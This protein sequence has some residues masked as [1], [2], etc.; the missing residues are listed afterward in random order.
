MTPTKTISRRSF[1]T[2]TATTAAAITIVPRYVLGRGF[3]PP[4]DTLNIAGVGVGGMGRANLINLSSQNIVALCDVDWGYAGKSLDRLDTEIP[5]L[6]KRLDEPAPTTP[7]Q[8]PAQPGQLAASTVRPRQSKN[9]PRPHDPPEKRSPPQSQALPGLSRD[10]REAKGH[11]RGLRRH[12]RP[13]ARHDR[14]RGDGSGQARLRAKAPHVVDRGSAP[15]FAT[16][17]RNQSRHADGQPGALPRRRPHRRRVRAI[18]RDRRGPRNPHLD[19]PPAGF[20]A[21]RRAAS[22]AL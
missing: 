10:A 2:K 21:A 12:A 9:P 7:Q 5:A 3:V 15:P 8:S 14:S 16:R 19:Q 11:R 17:R 22:R 20:L 4:S 6:Q 13:H 18:R 1:L